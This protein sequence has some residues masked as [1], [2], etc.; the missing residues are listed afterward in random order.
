MIIREFEYEDLQQ[1]M[2]IVYSSFEEYYTSDFFLTIW[3][4]S[5]DGFIVADD[6]E[7]I[8]GFV[9]GVMVDVETLRILMICVREGY[10]NKGIGSE[11]LKHIIK[12]SGNV[13]KVRLEVKMS[14]K[15]AIRFYKKYGFVIKE[16]LPD[17]YPDG[18]D[19]YLMEKSLF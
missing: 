17:F 7:K 13:R 12:K 8:V 19:A 9:M 6:G 1:V 2:E 18:T 10:R 15:E 5:P 16:T 3:Q 4:A 11:L 14:N